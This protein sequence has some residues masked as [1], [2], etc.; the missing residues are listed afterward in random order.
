M[1]AR[2]Y[3]SARPRKLTLWLLVGCRLIT[4]VERTF[5]LTQ[6]EN[7]ARAL[8]PTKGIETCLD[9]FE[10]GTVPFNVRIND[11]FKKSATLQG[12][13]TVTQNEGKFQTQ[14]TY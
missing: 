9:P 6:I 1:F 4:F 5:V 7:E 14:P 12:G 8:S 3:L 11:W 10:N 13:L 2:D